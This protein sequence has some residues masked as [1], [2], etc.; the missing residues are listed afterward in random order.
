M[1]LEDGEG[2]RMTK[3]KTRKGAGAP[4]FCWQCNRQL[5]RAEGKGLGLFYFAV[6]RDRDGV[7]HRVHGGTCRREAIADG[8]KDVT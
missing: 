7:E 3:V 6:V 4:S 8:N 2:P 1:G 5:M